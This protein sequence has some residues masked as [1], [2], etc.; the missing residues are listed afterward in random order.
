MK[1]RR[2]AALLAAAFLLFLMTPFAT[3]QGTKE[4]DKIYDAV[5]RKL[6]DDVDVKGGAF[7]VI[8]KDG[9]VVLKGRVH[10]EKDKEKATRITKKVKGVTNVDNQLKLFSAE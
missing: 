5:R 6:A 4:D 10:T 7:E 1:L 2:A 8:V 3:A 9:M